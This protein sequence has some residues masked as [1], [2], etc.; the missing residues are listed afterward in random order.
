QLPA[1]FAWFGGMLRQFDDLAF[2]DAANLIQVQAAFSL[3]GLGLLGGTEK[4]V[5]NHGH[6]GPR[7]AAHGQRPFSLRQPLSQ[8]RTPPGTSR[9]KALT[10]IMPLDPSRDILPSRRVPGV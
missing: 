7:G 8:P 2:G 4:R 6:G 5:G 9:R 10:V 3:H 1:F